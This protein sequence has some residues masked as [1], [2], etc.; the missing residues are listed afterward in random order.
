MPKKTGKRKSRYN[1]SKAN[2][3]NSKANIQ[4]IFTLLNI[5]IN[6]NSEQDIPEKDKKIIIKKIITYI[7]K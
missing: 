2:K 1:Y 6:D 4:E 3:N 7:K 5:D